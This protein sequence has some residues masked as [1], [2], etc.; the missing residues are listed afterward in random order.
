MVRGN[1]EIQDTDPWRC[2]IGPTWSIMTGHQVWAGKQPS[3]K[4]P[5]AP[6]PVWQEKKI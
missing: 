5:I 2:Q 6:S 3:S 4:H 1:S